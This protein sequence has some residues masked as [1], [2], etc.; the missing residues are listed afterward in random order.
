MSQNVKRIFKKPTNFFSNVA[1]MPQIWKICYHLYKYSMF[2]KIVL[3]ELLIMSLLLPL[4][5]LSKSS[6][7]FS[8]LTIEI[9][10]VKYVQSQQ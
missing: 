1:N 7:T 8:K 2:K 3:D 6:F 9:Q 10:G 5:H 4:L